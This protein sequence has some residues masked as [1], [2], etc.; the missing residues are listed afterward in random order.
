VLVAVIDSRV[1]TA[2][3]ALAESVRETYSAFDS[4]APEPDTHG[5]AMAGAIAGRGQILGTAPGAALLVAECFAK[6]ESG[7]M[8]GSTFHLLKCIDWAHGR[9]AKIYN[10]SFA[11]PR[12]P[13]LSRLMKD[14]AGQGAVFVAA[15]G[16]AGANSPPQFPAADENAIA[17]TAVDEQQRLYKR[18]VR[19]K[20]VA[21]AAPGVDVVVLAPDNSVG[22]STGTS[23]ATAHVAGLAALAS[24]KTGG[25]DRDRLRKLLAGSARK[26][27]APRNSIGAGLADALRLVQDAAALAP[28][29]TVQR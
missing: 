23:V 20:H 17:V 8:N 14:A 7:K 4:P 26:I 3:P 9:A 12:D 28:P 19:G 15:A 1:D 6:D 16:N 18:A 5:T 10:M 11:G 29:S 22:L 25:L 13:M 27:K 21:I 24:E 2:H